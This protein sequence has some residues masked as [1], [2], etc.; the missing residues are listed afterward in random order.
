M[1]TRHPRDGV[2][3]APVESGPAR[4]TGLP[5]AARAHPRSARRM[6]A[7]VASA[8]TPGLLILWLSFDDGGTPSE[9][10]A[11]AAALLALLLLG[12]IVLAPA[13]VRRPSALGITA[14]ASLG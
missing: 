10:A 8:A 6:H 2:T 7:V 12:R 9:T 1:A 13:S 11:L 3:N 4:M 5:T 14:M